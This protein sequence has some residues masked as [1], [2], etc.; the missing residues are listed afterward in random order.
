M[1]NQ[2]GK[3]NKENED[4][5][6]DN[7]QNLDAKH[8]GDAFNNKKQI[9]S[10]DEDKKKEIEEKQKIFIEENTAVCLE[11]TEIFDG[12]QFYLDMLVNDGNGFT[13]KSYPLP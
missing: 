3:G 8:I 10:I 6:G 2:Q 11:W 13:K 9:D 7:A 4:K 1:I 12:R 5:F